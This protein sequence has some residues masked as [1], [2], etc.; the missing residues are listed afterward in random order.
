MND[1][2][3]WENEFQPF[4]LSKDSTALVRLSNHVQ[5]VR[6]APNLYEEFLS[7]KNVLDHNGHLCLLWVISNCANQLWA[8]SPQKV[9]DTQKVERSAQCVAKFEMDSWRN[10]FSRP[11]HTEKC[12]KNVKTYHKKFGACFLCTQKYVKINIVHVSTEAMYITTHLK[13]IQGILPNTQICTLT[14]PHIKFLLYFFCVQPLI[15]KNAM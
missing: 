7:N 11:C 6:A 14:P 2:R 12:H 8:M 1:S 10:K 13:I 9:L 5:F 4:L 15:S 3:L